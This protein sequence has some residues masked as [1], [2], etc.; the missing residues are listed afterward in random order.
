MSSG[1]VMVPDPAL[2]QAPKQE[3]RALV[4]VAARHN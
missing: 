4:W 1:F 2:L 3:P